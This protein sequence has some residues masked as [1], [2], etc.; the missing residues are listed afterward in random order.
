MIDS[1]EIALGRME[2]RIFHQHGSVA[3]YNDNVCLDIIKSDFQIEYLVVASNK[4]S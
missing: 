3:F 4:Y 1:T 2:T